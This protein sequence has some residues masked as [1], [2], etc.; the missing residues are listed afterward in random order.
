MEE[1]C[2]CLFILAEMLRKISIQKRISGIAPR[3]GEEPDLDP[4]APGV[5]SGYSPDMLQCK[6]SYFIGILPSYHVL[7]VKGLIVSCW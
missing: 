6:A 7:E 4:C 3:G 2:G 5:D 1:T